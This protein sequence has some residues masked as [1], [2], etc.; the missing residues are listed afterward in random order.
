[1]RPSEILTR[2]TLYL[3]AGA[4]AALAQGCTVWDASYETQVNCD[5]TAWQGIVNYDWQ[6]AWGGS[7]GVGWFTGGNVCDPGGLNCNGSSR[8]PALYKATKIL[9]SWSQFGDQYVQFWW[10]INEQYLHWESCLTPQGQTGALVT[11]YSFTHS[12]GWYSLW[13]D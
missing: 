2:S 9:N 7:Y 3:A 12:S 13:C 10:N 5:Y 1:M 8:E 11:N 6:G 4:A